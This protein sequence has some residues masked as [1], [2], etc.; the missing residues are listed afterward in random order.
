VEFSIPSVA[1]FILSATAVTNAGG[2]YQAPLNGIQII[3]D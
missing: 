3:P 2:P 1:G